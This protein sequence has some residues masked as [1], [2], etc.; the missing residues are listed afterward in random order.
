[1][2]PPGRCDGRNGVA[3]IGYTQKARYCLTGGSGF[4]IMDLYLLEQPDNLTVMHSLKRDS[5][6][7]LYYQISEH[8]R[9][10]IEGGALKP[11]ERI[12]SEYELV[13]EYGVSR[14]TARLAIDALISQGLV[15]RVQGKGTFVTRPRLRYGLMQ[16]SSFSEEMQRRGWC[17]RSEVLE[18]DAGEPP[19]K[20]SQAMQMVPGETAYKI[21]R[22]RLANDEPM[23]LHTSYVPCRLCPGLE[24]ED[25]SSGSLYVLLEERYG[26]RI[27]YA[28][29]V[30][31]PAVANEM[32]ARLL[33]IRPGAPVLIVEGTAYLDYG[34][35]VE[36]ACLMYRGDRYEFPYHSVRMRTQGRDQTVPEAG[37]K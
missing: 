4:P 30:L 35:P 31:K 17:S 15:Y 10:L 29:Q 2:R 19:V 37:G 13:G 32:E 21:E 5:F 20:I 16:L 28:E 18:L 33:T 11:G 25:L 1:V 22:L 27:A 9:A 7:P 26:L 24:R 14:N 12:P 34:S 6:A 3:W 36:Y 23:A 8:L